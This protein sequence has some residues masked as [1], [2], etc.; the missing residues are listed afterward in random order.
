M[1]Y[2]LTAILEKNQVKRGVAGLPMAQLKI[3][4]T[5]LSEHSR[6]VEPKRINFNNSTGYKDNFFWYRSVVSAADKQDAPFRDSHLQRLEGVHRILVYYLSQYSNRVPA[7]KAHSY[8]EPYTPLQR[9]E[10]KSV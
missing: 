10:V 5:R 3:L 1:P 6:L 4:E 9:A 2:R 7:F 8:P